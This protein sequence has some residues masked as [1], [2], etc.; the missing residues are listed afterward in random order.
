MPDSVGRGTMHPLG[1]DKKTD[2]YKAVPM[3]KNYS[4]LRLVVT[5]ESHS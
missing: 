4:Q 2:L 5:A 3:I 1:N